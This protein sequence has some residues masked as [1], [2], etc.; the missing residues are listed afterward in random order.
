MKLVDRIAQ[1]LPFKKKTEVIPKKT[2]E[3]VLDAA[4]KLEVVKIAAALKSERVSVREL[5]AEEIPS[6]TPEIEEKPF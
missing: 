6:D 1:L 2:V 4:L 5:Y 3:Q